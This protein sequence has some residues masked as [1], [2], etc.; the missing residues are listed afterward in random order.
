M[1]D[2]PPDY[3]L[4]LRAFLLGTGDVIALVQERIFAPEVPQG[5]ADD[6]PRK[7]AVLRPAGGGILTSN[8]YMQLGDPRID[9]FSYGETPYEADRVHRA[10]YGA[11]KQMRRNV[12]GEALLHWAKPS[13]AGLPLRDPDTEWPYV[14]SSWQVLVAEVPIT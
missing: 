14:L 5:E 4:G 9:I 12:Q 2:T 8:S 11:L 3:V 7:C 10:V 13:T 6:M 1:S